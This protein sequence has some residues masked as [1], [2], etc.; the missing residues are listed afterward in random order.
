LCAETQF[1]RRDEERT[2]D[3]LI[4]AA[5]RRDHAVAMKINEK[6]LNILRSANGAW[7]LGDGMMTLFTNTITTQTLTEA[8]NRVFWKLDVWEDD[9]RRRKRFVPNPYGS[10]H[11][12]AAARV[13]GQKEDTTK[14]EEHIEK[15]REHLLAQ[16]IAKKIVVPPAS[17]GRM[18]GVTTM[19]ADLIDE[20]DIATMTD[21]NAQE[22]EDIGNE[23]IT[24][25]TNDVTF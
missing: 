4:T 6:L 17:G 21:A 22:P 12:D 9:S 15:A 24:Y 10:Q 18:A 8:A 19:L 5:R 23:I 14:A 20:N 3:H 16:L 2:C 7:T 11:E 1:D 25:A 13:P